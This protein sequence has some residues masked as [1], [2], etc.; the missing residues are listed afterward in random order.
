[1]RQIDITCLLVAEVLEI[2]REAG[3]AIMNV[4]EEMRGGSAGAK[5]VKEVLVAYKADNSPLTRADLVAHQVISRG[6]AVLT[7]GIP[8]VSEEDEQSLKYRLP[9]GDFWLVDPLDGTKEF[10]AKNGEFT[11]NIALVRDGKTVLGVVVAPALGQA[12]WGGGGLGAFR[13]IHN[14]V[15]PIRVANSAR[16]DQPMRVVASRSHMNAETVEFIGQLGAHELVQAGSSLKFC[17]VAEG[18]ADIYPRLG[19]TCEWDTAAAQA[20]IEAAGGHVSKLDGT[21]VQYGKP[22]V[23]N[24]HFVVSSTPLTDL[25]KSCAR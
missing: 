18:A 9:S 22:G 10:L 8:V 24:P 2:A 11:V 19:P 20:I 25:L 3:V 5:E 6:L 21:P 23:L 17:R 14:R 7:P 16:A 13:E 4:Y 1:M 15:E 12:Y